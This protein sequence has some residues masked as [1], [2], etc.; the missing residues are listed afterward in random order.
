MENKPFI[1]K[2]DR[3]IKLVEKVS[4]ASTTGAETTSS[5]LVS[6]PWACMKDLSGTEDVEGKIRHLVNRTYLVRYNPVIKEKGTALVLID[7]GKEY[8]I[9]HI[10][11]IGRKDHLELRVKLYE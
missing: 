9:I 2:K 5:V 7:E 1:G 3:K 6:E 4:I 8:E 10:L 11:N